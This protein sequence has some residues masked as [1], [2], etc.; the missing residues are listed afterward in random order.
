LVPLV[1]Y[2]LCNYLHNSCVLGTQKNSSL[3]TPIGHRNNH[4]NAAH[5]LSF[6]A[7]IVF[8][9]IVL[10]T[11]LIVLLP[12]EVISALAD[13]DGLIENAGALSFFL[14][15]VLFFIAYGY[16]SG[17]K[18]HFC[19]YQI[20]RNVFYFLLGILFLICFGEEISWGQRF[21]HWATPGWLESIN[22]QGETNLHNI[23]VFHS[24]KWDGTPKTGL[25]AQ[26]NM[27]QLFRL[28]WWL[29][30]VVTP[31][32]C[33]FSRR[34]REWCEWIGLP[35]VPLWIGGLFIA[36]GAV[37]YWVS[38]MLTQTDRGIH[39]DINELKETNYAIIFLILA[40]WELRKTVFSRRQPATETTA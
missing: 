19:G 39:S 32:A 7:I 13:E 28:F 33:T 9:L 34:I 25:A 26:L 11:C 38:E 16:S 40:F 8:Y 3:P 30:C 35:I 17:L 12:P 14:A 2:H 23:D 10:S 24:K 27:N 22:V 4:L 18:S 29:F 6:K 31:L 37:F 36:H 15:S 21:F 20:Q 5:A 1:I